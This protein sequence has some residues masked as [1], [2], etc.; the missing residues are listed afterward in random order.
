MIYAEFSNQEKLLLST[1]DLK[2]PLPVLQ[3]N[4]P[5]Q[6]KILKQVSK[7]VDPTDPLLK[8]LIQK[9]YVTVRLGKR[10][11]VGIAAPQLGFLKRV[12]LVQRFDKKDEPYE[13]FINPEIVWSS[14]IFQLNQEGCL[15]IENV[16]KDV[17]RSLVIQITYYDLQSVQYQ[18][19]IEGFTA[20]II[21]HEMD[22]LNG[23]LFTDRV[24]D[25]KENHY[26]QDQ[27]LSNLYYLKDK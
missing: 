6:L 3:V 2:E 14:T 25:E 22:H 26:V 1:G 4:T 20:V 21:Q 18:E 11:G 15:S 23:I 24:E 9:L 16:H 13:F 12:F 8:D 10:K 19:V 27:R 5:E 7:V 17:F